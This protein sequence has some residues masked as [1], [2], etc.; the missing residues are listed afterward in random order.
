MTKLIKSAI[1][2]SMGITFLTSTSLADTLQGQKIYVKKLKNVC[3]MSGGRFAAK[4]TEDEWDKIFKQGKMGEEIAKICHGFKIEEELIPHI[5][6]FVK[7]YASDSG[8]VPEC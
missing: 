4:H 1:I 6:D 5:H 3:G 7:K 2:A 8:N